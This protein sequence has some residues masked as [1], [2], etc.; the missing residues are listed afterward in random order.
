MWLTCCSASRSS[1]VS[2]YPWGLHLL[3]R[4]VGGLED[5]LGLSRFSRQFRN[6]VHLR[7]MSSVVTP[8]LSPRSISARV[9]HERS[10]SDPIPSCTEI[11]VIAPW[12]WPVCLMA[13]STILIASPFSSGG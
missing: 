7:A 2:R 9:Y 1:C 12:R 6:V 5:M 3:H 10:V 13:S 8:G 11:R 4:S